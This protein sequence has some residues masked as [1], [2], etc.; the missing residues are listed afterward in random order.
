MDEE[1]AASTSSSSKPLL[2]KKRR[3]GENTLAEPADTP[4]PQS[5]SGAKKGSRRIWKYEDTEAFQV[6]D[7]RFEPP[8]AVK[9]PFQYFKTL[10]TDEVIE[11]IAQHTNLYSAQELGDPIK[12]LRD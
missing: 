11:H 2:R 12:P 1:E 7:S 5:P 9:T 3:K 6:P 8:D 4:K 10:F